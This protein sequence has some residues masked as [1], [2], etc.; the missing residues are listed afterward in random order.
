MNEEESIHEHSDMS[1]D[2]PSMVT[3]ESTSQKASDSKIAPPVA[4]KP[5]WF[6]QSLRKLQ[7]N[8]DQRKQA[9]YSE[10][11]TTAGVTR[12]FGGRSTSGGVN[13]SLR[14]KICSFETFSSPEAQEK[15]TSRRSTPFSNSPALMERESASPC[16]S[17]PASHADDGESKQD[18]LEEIK[19][20]QSTSVVI[21]NISV[22]PIGITSATYENCCQI[23]GT[24][25]EDQ[26]SCDE[27]PINIPLSDPICSEITSVVDDVNLASVHTD[28]KFPPS[29]QKS[30]LEKADN[31]SSIEI[32]A[33]PS[34]SSE[35]MN[36]KEVVNNSDENSGINSEL[37]TTAQSASPTTECQPQKNQE[38]KHFEK[39]LAFSNQF[40]QAIM[41]SLPTSNHGNP[42]SQEFMDAPHKNLDP[43]ESELGTICTNKGFSISLA[44]LSE[45]TIEEGGQ[46]YDRATSAHSVIS[47]LP[48]QE[49]KKMIEEVRTLDDESFKRLVD[50]H[51]V[52]LHKEE[53]TGLGFSIA[54]GCDLENK[55]PTVHKVF[56][57][58]LAAR[59][60]TIQK[61]DEVLSINGLT[62]HGVKH[63]DATAIL[64]QARNQ[65]LAVVVINKRT[66]ED[67]KDG[68]N[69][70]G[71]DGSVPIGEQEAPLRIDLKKG[72]AGL[73]FSLEGGRGS[74]QGDRPLVIN[75]IFKGGAAEQ[76]GLQCG[77]ELLQVQGESL[78]DISRFEA[79]NM[80]KALPEGPVKLLI[81]R[82]Q[83]TDE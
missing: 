12:S 10:E 22:S 14:Q 55:A 80:I 61:G 39:I 38:G 71:E 72:A 3:S 6:K 20:D 62:L 32:S 11:K 21:E 17:Y 77:D 7:D 48:S 76:S 57:S 8:Q 67:N 46:S 51:V 65:T 34:A 36:Q 63:M 42:Q 29:Q 5:T 82:K 75:R 66:D 78:Q 47:V 52:I 18:F 27:I 69:M 1:P 26:L 68:G 35:R 50:I 23:K 28:S 64:R 40:S 56:I 79:W 30:E 25:S 15:R 45:C 16:H 19:S 73:G 74:I 60:G 13:M 2:P 44:T 49:I 4:P 54:G 43:Q 70:K 37:L 83:G 9:N 58:G 59:E 33:P 41:R 81:R 31:S 53:G 24:C